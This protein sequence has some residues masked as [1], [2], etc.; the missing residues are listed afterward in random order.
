MKLF[1]LFLPEEWIEKLKT[2]ARQQSA[3]QNTNI[4]V[5]LLIRKAI[6]KEYKLWEK[7]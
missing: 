1:T 2:I 5:A 4:S 3:K 7:N 6:K